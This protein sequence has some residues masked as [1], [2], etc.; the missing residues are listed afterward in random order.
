MSYVYLDSKHD[1]FF[2]DEETYTTI[3]AL[4]KDH[5]QCLYDYRN[6]HSYTP[7]NPCVGK[8]ICLEH[9]LQ[10]QSHLVYAGQV[11]MDSGNRCI[12]RFVDVKGL[13][14]TA[15]EDSSEDAKPN[16]LE[17]LAYYGFTPPVKITVRGKSVDFYAYYANIHGDLHSASVIVLSYNQYS[18]K[19]KGLFLLYKH[20]PTKELSKK[21]DVYRRAEEL[22]EQSKDAHGEYHIG[23]RTHFNRYEADVLEVISQLES[24][25]YNVTLSLQN[26]MKTQEAA[27]I[28][29]EQ[30]TGDGHDKSLR[31]EENA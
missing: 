23:G 31:E 27:Q 3:A 12:H 18:E 10:K 19:I 28:V 13:I 5:K 4:V 24:A 15:T 7:E 20:G 11:G 16:T 6:R 1:E 14:Y 17:T 9:L 8:A 22:V 30:E 25:M 26:G 2:V 29:Q 21:S